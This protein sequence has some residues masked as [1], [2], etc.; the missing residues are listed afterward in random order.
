MNIEKKKIERRTK[1]SSIAK[2]AIAATF[3]LSARHFSRNFGQTPFDGDRVS[4][5][6]K[7][8]RKNK[9]KYN[10]FNHSYK[11]EKKEV[12]TQNL[13]VFNHYYGIRQ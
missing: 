9:R 10:L 12:K 8:S 5:K 13:F 11:L 7:G 1:L 3:G 2:K 6:H 4:G